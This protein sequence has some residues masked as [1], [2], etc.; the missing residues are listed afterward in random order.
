MDLSIPS[1]N[2]NHR[3]HTNSSII[4]F[5]RKKLFAFLLIIAT[6]LSLASAQSPAPSPSPPPSVSPSPP[7]EPSPTTTVTSAPATT[8][9]PAVTAPNSKLLSFTFQ[10]NTGAVLG[11]IDSIPLSSCV[12]ID[13]T[14]PSVGG[15][16]GNFAS[17]VAS[18]TQAALNLY[19][20]VNCKVLQSGAVGMWNNAGSV[21]NVAGASWVGTA[22]STDSPGTLVSAGFPALPITTTIPEPTQ[23]PDANNTSSANGGLSMDPSKGRVLVILVSCILVIGIIV[24][25]YQ[26]YEASLYTAPPKKAKKKK[27]DGLVGAKKIKKKNAY[28]VKPGAQEEMAQINS[29]KTGNNI[30]S[31]AGTGGDILG[32]NRS[33]SILLAPS[34]L[35]ERSRNDRSSFASVSSSS[36]PTFIGR[37]SPPNNTSVSPSGVTGYRVGREEIV[38]SESVLIDIDLNS[39][40]ESFFPSSATSTSFNPMTSDMGHSGYDRP[41]SPANRGGEVMLPMHQLDSNRQSPTRRTPRSP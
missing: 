10:D 35:H 36:A 4:K 26:V 40:H 14:N 37:L 15:S 2:N 5:P 30:M 13:P 32:S 33:T 11:Q 41:S 12:A 25:V 7:S 17:V 23:T 34:S 27:N 24:G 39:H 16:D 18:D 21:A 8:T 1:H 19:S 9:T 38:P 28:F 3:R 6:S 31:G 20:D 22:P 29:N